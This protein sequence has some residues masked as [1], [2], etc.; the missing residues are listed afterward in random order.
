MLRLSSAQ[1]L[2]FLMAALVELEPFRTCLGRPLKSRKV[3]LSSNTI[4]KIFKIK[5]IPSPVFKILIE[6]KENDNFPKLKKDK[7][8]CILIKE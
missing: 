4:Y 5:T 8:W 6:V 7:N 3:S 2:P 1:Q